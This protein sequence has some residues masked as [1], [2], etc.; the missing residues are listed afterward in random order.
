MWMS[1]LKKPFIIY[2][3]LM[4]RRGYSFGL[5]CFEPLK[6]SLALTRLS[7]C[8]D[9][10]QSWKT[11]RTF[12][13]NNMTATAFS[14]LFLVLSWLDFMRLCPFC[15][16]VFF[17]GRTFLL[18]L[19]TLVSKQDNGR[20]LLW[21]L[22]TLVSKLADYLL[23]QGN[24]NEVSWIKAE[25]DKRLCRG[26]VTKMWNGVKMCLCSNRNRNSVL[27]CFDMIWGLLAQCL[28]ASLWFISKCAS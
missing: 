6:H 2:L 20:N 18:Y 10:L 27:W 19:P 11:F 21:F 26:D 15:G 5:I 7:W 8:T 4:I 28:Q 25:D 23:L 14:S 17:Q 9:L 3:T 13:D 16:G 12:I 1:E 24:R 22:H